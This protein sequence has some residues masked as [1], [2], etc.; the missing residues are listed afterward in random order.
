[1]HLV[2]RQVT[3]TVEAQDQDSKGK[4]KTKTET[5]MVKAET[6]TVKELKLFTDRFF[7]FPRGSHG[8]KIRLSKMIFRGIQWLL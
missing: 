5:M 8:T 1:M 3:W 2:S 7:P 4:T 6:M